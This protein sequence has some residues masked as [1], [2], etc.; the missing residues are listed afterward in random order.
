MLKKIALALGT[1]VMV[2]YLLLGMSHFMY[3]LFGTAAFYPAFLLYLGA[4]STITQVLYRQAEFGRG[5]STALVLG[6]VAISLVL[7][8]AYVLPG[9]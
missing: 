1:M 5:L 3:S 4:V 9:A 7:L 8:G 6:S 2:S